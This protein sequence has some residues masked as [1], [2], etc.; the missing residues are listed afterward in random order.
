[1]DVDVDVDEDLVVDA[2]GHPMATEVQ[3]RGL[4]SAVGTSGSSCLP[5]LARVHVHD[6]VHDHVATCPSDSFTGS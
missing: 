6:Y 1:V 4:G 5:S 3:H 2:A